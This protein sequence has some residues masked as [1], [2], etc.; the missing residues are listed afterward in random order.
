EHPHQLVVVAV[1]DARRHL[2][3]TTHD[4]DGLASM[5]AHIPDGLEPC[6]QKAAYGLRVFLEESL[7]H[8]KDVDVKNLDPVPELYEHA[9]A[10]VLLHLVAGIGL[11]DHAVDLACP[12]RGH[13]R[14]GRAERR[15]IDAGR[16]PAH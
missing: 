12:Q 3:G 15:Q 2:G 6:G 8:V 14:G 9:T 5:L 1:G 4:V 7:A 10:A 13:L 11:D 16:T